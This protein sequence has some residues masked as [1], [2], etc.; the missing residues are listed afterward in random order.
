MISVLMVIPTFAPIVGGAE[1]QLEGIAP[2]LTDLGCALEIV[3]RRLPGTPALDETAGYRVR[4]LNN[5]GFRLG[6]HI[7]LALFL[8]MHGRRYRL[9]H[10]HTLSGP[11]L[12][13]AIIGALLRR[14]VLLKVTRSGPGS[15]IQ[16]WQSSSLRR[17]I[18]RL[19]LLS[20]T[21]VI[22]ISSDTHAELR[23]LGV[24]E[25]R[26]THIPNG[27]DVLARRDRLSVGRPTIIY[28]GR[29]IP[30]KRVDL[31]L[32]AFAACS[33]VR[34]QGAILRI[35][36]IGPEAGRLRQLASKL[37]IDDAVHFLGELEHRHLLAELDTADIFV[38]PSDS[39]G[40]SNSLLEA[41]A[42]GL[43]VIGADI[44][45][46]RDLIEP[47]ITGLTFRTEAMLSEQ[48]GKLIDD[49]VMR[50]R[51][52]LAA[53]R[54]MATCFSFGA[55]AQAYYDLYKAIIIQSQRV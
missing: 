30:R 24:P 50:R 48:I 40:M 55:V 17:L 23:R 5:L 27:V 11:A 49:A 26:V 29:L 35:A 45:A 22:S 13:C 38:L 36:G 54:R 12:I 53:H 42:S 7:S 20:G 16:S 52:A 32:R 15:Q 44:I 4:R 3:T 25:N 21:R 43:A 51:L 6:F 1:R 18:F 47:G 34:S 31:L 2:I 37:D 39:E 33:Q 9:I 10:C 19:M 8:L 46:N 41:M 14:P 28:S